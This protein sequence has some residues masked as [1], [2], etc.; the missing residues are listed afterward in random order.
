MI[1]LN[2]EIYKIYKQITLINFKIYSK[3]ML[4]NYKKD[5]IQY[6]IPTKKVNK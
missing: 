4:Q 6:N 2:K 1:L 3:I 5:L